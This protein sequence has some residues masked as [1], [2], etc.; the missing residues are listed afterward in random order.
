MEFICD[1]Y[2]LEFICDLYILS[3][4]LPLG[5]FLS[6]ICEIPGYTRKNIIQADL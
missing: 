2:I 6:S 5:E 1:L 4:F 3:V